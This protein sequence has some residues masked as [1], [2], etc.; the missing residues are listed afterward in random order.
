M[1]RYGL[2]QLSDEGVDRS[3]GVVAN[4]VGCPRVESDDVTV[5][6]HVWLGASPVRAA[7]AAGAAIEPDADEPRAVPEPVTQIDLS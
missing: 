6:G 3:V 5:G 4:Q 1:A 7:A 2:P